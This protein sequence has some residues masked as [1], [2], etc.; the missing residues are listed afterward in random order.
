MRHGTIVGS[1]CELMK[2]TAAFTVASAAPEFITHYCGFTVMKVQVNKLIK[3][4]RS[5]ESESF[6]RK[7]TVGRRERGRRE[8]WRS[9]GE[10][11]ARRGVEEGDKESEMSLRVRMRGRKV[12]RVRAEVE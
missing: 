2:L 8:R 3:L 12:K 4:G 9:E 5:R 7:F 1:R 10:A 11:D 6:G